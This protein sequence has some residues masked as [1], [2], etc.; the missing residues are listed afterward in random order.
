MHIKWPLLIAAIAFVLLPSSMH[1]QEAT[2]ATSP[3]VSRLKAEAIEDQIKLSWKDSA[4]IKGTLLVYRHT[5]EIV[6]KNFGQALA[7]ERVQPGAE[8]YID[9]PPD[10]KPYFYAV[11]IEDRNRMPYKMLVPF[12][13]K[14][15]AG[16]ALTVAP[17]EEQ[18]AARITGISAMV[19]PGEELVAISFRAS[20]PERDLLLFW[21][22]SPLTTSEDLLL[23]ASKTQ[24]DAGVTRY[25]I[26]TIPGIDY[27]FAVID[28]GLYKL[29]KAPLEKGKNTTSV[30]VQI[31]LATT[32][33]ST[34]SRRALPL[35]ALELGF[36]VQS[37][38][39][40]QSAE[41]PALP[42]EK[43]LSSAT[44][45][46]IA[47]LLKGMQDT[48]VPPMKPQILPADATPSPG[49]QIAALQAIVR[50]AFASQDMATAE[51]QLKNYLSLRREKETETRARFYLAQAYFFQG[52]VRESL[53]EFL[54]TEDSL[55]HET[56]AWK[57]ACLRI[58]RAGSVQ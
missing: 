33:S 19:P 29:G 30:P 20:N 27:Y 51:R 46:A 4:D 28:A 16:V 7:I 57:D 9:T 31:P 6:D 10:Q 25:D 39:I 3:F 42:A 49:G 37:G 55:Y 13:N 24:I 22:T 45:K 23:S 11:L 36:G 53:L 40:L 18:Q 54:L 15:S 2:A 58:L 35:P 43:K 56:Q 21:G 5:E 26:P 47:Q 1:G 8:F 12:R 52:R 48:P 44:T 32:A 17:S 50:G 34:F 41:V 14:T 38:R